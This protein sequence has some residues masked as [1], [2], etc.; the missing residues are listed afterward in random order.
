MG[1]RKKAHRDAEVSTESLNDIMFFL[2]LFFLILSTMVSPNA[3][4]VNLPSSKPTKPVENNKKPIHLDVSNNRNYFVEGK[5]VDY[6][7]LEATLVAAI[8]GNPEPTVVLQMDKDLSI[9]DAVDVMIIVDKLKCK[10]VWAT[11]PSNGK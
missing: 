11:K 8:N 6:S 1:L 4:K 5:E 7:V 3:I 10:M 2:L 9:Q